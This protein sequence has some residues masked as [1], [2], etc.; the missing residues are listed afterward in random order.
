MWQTDGLTD[1]VATATTLVQNLS[2]LAEDLE[3]WDSQEFRDF[4]AQRGFGLAW[5]DPGEFRTWM[6][7]SDESLASVMDVLFDGLSPR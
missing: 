3:I 6:A 7:E 2:N 5:G 4:M 1:L